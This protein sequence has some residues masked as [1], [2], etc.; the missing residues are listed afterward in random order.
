MLNRRD[1]PPMFP[2]VG[3]VSVWLGLVKRINR[4]TN[5]FDDFLPLHLEDVGYHQTD[6][7]L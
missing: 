1:R 7:H 5:G 6:L 2:L 3:C 4:V